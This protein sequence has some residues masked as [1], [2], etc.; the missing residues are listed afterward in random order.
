M[1]ILLVS[2]GNNQKYGGGFYYALHRRLLN[3]FVRAGHCVFTYS[4]R[5]TADYALGIRKLGRW[6]ANRRLVDI[7]AGYKPELLVLMQSHMIDPRTVAQVRK[8]APGVKVAAI[9]IDDISHPTPAGQFRHLLAGADFGFATTGGETLRAFTGPSTVAFIPNPVDAS[10]DTGRAF[11]AGRHDYDLF[12]SG[13]Q[14]AVDR[15]WAFI[16]DLTGRLP[17]SVRTGIFGRHQERAIA[18]ADYIATLSASR[19]GL[20]LNRRDGD[21]YASDRMAHLLG[22]G[23]LL[24]THADSGYAAHFGDDEMIF[25]R[26]AADLAGHIEEALADDRGWRAR[27][28][29]GYEKARVTMSETLVAR[30]IVALAF[31]E[32]LPAEWRFTDHIFGPRAVSRALSDAVA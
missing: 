11:A 32:S 10:M 22:N 15:R 3:G 23:L 27:A 7:A 21:L 28:K 29:A 19:I 13:H 9:N 31:G 12:F 16:D 25:Y 18:G 24:A 2:P 6:M 8:V 20:N 14:P 30:F 17:D 26:D 1:R 4:D 5:D